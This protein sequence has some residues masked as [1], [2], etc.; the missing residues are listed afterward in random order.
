V[1][2]IRQEKDRGK[3]KNR[4]EIKESNGVFF[5]I[6]AGTKDLSCAIGCLEYSYNSPWEFLSFPLGIRIISPWEFV[7]FPPTWK[8]ILFPPNNAAVIKRGEDGQK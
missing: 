6:Q 5:S 1:K 3:E 2:S 8:S 4:A 7:L